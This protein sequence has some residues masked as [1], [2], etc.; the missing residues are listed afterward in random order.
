[1][2]TIKD[3]DMLT[4]LLRAVFAALYLSL[5][6]TSIALVSFQRR[7]WQMAADTY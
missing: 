3:R 6:I 7:R 4:G 2:L 5:S 1:M